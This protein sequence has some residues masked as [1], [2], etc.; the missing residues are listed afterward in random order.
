VTST[1]S[2]I[3]HAALTIHA[4]IERRS[5]VHQPEGVSARPPSEAARNDADEDKVLRTVERL[6]DRFDGSVDADLL[7]NRVRAVFTHFETAPVQE[8]VPIL[9]E[10]ELR[11]EFER[12]A[13][14]A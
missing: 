5:P 9:A 7:E 2:T 1:D 3:P 4:L 13:G 11:R 10:R 6:R 8:F 14:V 12:Q